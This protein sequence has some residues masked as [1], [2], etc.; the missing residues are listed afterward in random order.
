MKL[1][2]KEATIKKEFSIKHKFIHFTTKERAKKIMVLDI[3]ERG[4]YKIAF[5]TN[6]MEI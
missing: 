6:F 4:N 1:F 3:P 5:I 2:I